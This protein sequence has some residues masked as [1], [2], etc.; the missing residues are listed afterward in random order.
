MREQD[1]SALQWVSATA[2]FTVEGV[3]D[4]TGHVRQRLDGV[5]RH[6][7][8]DACLVVV[9][10]RTLSEE[11]L[12]ACHRAPHTHEDVATRKNVEEGVEVV[13]VR[14]V[15]PVH[16]EIRRTT[17]RRRKDLESGLRGTVAANLASH[18]QDTAVRHDKARRV[19]TAPLEGKLG[20]YLSRIRV[21]DKRTCKWSSSKF[22]SQSFVPF[23]PGLPSGA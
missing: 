2:R 17:L 6:R 22:S 19:P 18:D 21:Q 23:T 20:S 11:P 10:Y 5:E 7:V 3:D 9:A 4:G 12:Y 8:Q 1:S 14:A 13:G 16:K 15:K